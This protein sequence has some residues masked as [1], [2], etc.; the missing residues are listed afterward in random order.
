[1]LT[2]I[3]P[4]GD[5]SFEKMDDLCGAVPE[6]GT[7]PYKPLTELRRMGL[8]VTFY[9]T[10]DCSRFLEAHES[11][12]LEQ[13][14]PEGQKYAMEQ[15]DI[16]SALIYAQSYLDAVRANTITEKNEYYTPETVRRLLD[17][18]FLINLWVNSRKLNGLEGMLGHFILVYDYDDTGFFAHDPGGNYPDGAPENQFEARYIEDNKLI[19]AASP[20]EFG[21]TDDLIAIRVKKREEKHAKAH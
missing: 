3:F 1:M 2:S 20:L 4:E 14:G 6:K 7:W 17:E 9:S 18:G 21:K 13:Y 19:D 5:W 11:Y 16:S 12:L 10:F 15:S 8:D